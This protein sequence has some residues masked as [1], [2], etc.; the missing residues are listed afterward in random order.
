M[1][2]SDTTAMLRELIIKSAPDPQQAMPVM[3]CD[4]DEPLDGIIPFSSIIILGTIIAVEDR[5]KIKVTRDV[6]ERALAGGVTV[7]RLAN[8]IQELQS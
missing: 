4:V 6:L 5:F 7:R 2:M 3:N 1:V 8:M